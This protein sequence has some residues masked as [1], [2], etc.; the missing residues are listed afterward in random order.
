MFIFL[1]D[2]ISVEL[3]PSQLYQPIAW[4]CN[5]SGYHVA[6]NKINQ[7]SLGI[8]EVFPPIVYAIGQ[9]VAVNVMQP[10]LLAIQGGIGSACRD[11]VGI[12]G[13]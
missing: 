12:R 4:N 3:H 13:R 9:A 1:L 8:Q 5:Q 6:V 7:A 10:R 11:Q 2:P